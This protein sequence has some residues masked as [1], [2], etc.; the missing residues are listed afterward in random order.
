[1]P[2]CLINLSLCQCHLH[3]CLSVCQ[4][5]L[6]AGMPLRN[7]CLYVSMIYVS[8]KLLSVCQ[9]VAYMSALYRFLFFCMLVLSVGLYMSILSV[10]QCVNII[11]LSVCHCYFV[12]VSV[13][14]CY[15]FVCVP[16][17]SVCLC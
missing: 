11:F 15:L 2:E 12:C 4:Y 14:P 5:Y 13:C 17:V 10:C 8:T 16:V 9:S 6:F 3:F 1:M 7:V